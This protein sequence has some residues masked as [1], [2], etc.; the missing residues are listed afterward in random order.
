MRRD[1]ALFF[2][3]LRAIGLVGDRKRTKTTIVVTVH[4]FDPVRLAPSELTDVTPT[5]VTL[6]SALCA[7]A[8]A[9]PFPNLVSAQGGGQS[10]LV[11]KHRA[12]VYQRKDPIKTSKLRVITGESQERE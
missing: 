8:D 7:C 10:G 6:L 12:G 11:W 5:A 2:F 9:S 1:P 3:F 4:F